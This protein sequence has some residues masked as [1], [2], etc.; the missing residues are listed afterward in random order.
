MIVEARRF[1]MDALVECHG[2][3]AKRR[4][5]HRAPH[6]RQ[7]R[8]TMRPPQRQ[9]AYRRQRLCAVQQSDAFLGFQPD[10]FDFG[11]AQGLAAGQQAALIHGLAFA[12]HAQRQ[13]GQGGQVTAGSNRPS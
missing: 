1:G 8:Q 10:G 3:P 5:G 2:G 11:Q 7:T 9:A 4:E 12:D 13:V 6:I